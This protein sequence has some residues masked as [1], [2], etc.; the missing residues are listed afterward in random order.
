MGASMNEDFTLPSDAS[1]PWF[2]EPTE[3]NIEAVI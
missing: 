3:Q 2:K 1:R